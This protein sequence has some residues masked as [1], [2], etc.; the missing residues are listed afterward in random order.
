MPTTTQQSTK[1]NIVLWIVQGLLAAL[2][3]FAGGMKFV[4][5]VA[6][7]TKGTTFSG[8]FIHFIGVAEVLG[9]LGLLL[10]GITKI[11]RELT[12]FAAVGL[13]M[14]MIGATT[15]TLASPQPSQGVVPAVVGVLA[16]L[17]AY[18]RRLPVGSAPRWTYRSTLPTS[19]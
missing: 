17:V 5:P 19:S 12:A 14:I 11:G 9:A 3:L 8:D 18:H 7:M 13:V 2:F 16:A 1:R 4:M 6:M 15:I 10:P